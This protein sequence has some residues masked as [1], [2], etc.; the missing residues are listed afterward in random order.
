MARGLADLGVLANLIPED[1]YVHGAWAIVFLDHADH[2][3]ALAYHDLTPEGYPQSKVFVKTTLADGGNIAVSSPMQILGGTLG[4]TGTI[5]VDGTVA[6]GRGGKIESAGGAPGELER[7]LAQRLE[8]EQRDHRGGS[9]TGVAHRLEDVRRAAAAGQH[10]QHVAPARLDREL[11]RED[12]VVA[13]VVGPGH[14]VCAYCLLPRPSDVRLQG[15]R[16]R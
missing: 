16:E 6:E 9:F 11:Q 2:A 13:F 15:L 14:E 5:T 7:D 10:D 1:G 3:H 8:A 12:P 4:G